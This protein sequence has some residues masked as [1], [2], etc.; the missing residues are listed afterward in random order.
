MI[1]ISTLD[2][3]E[4]ILSIEKTFGAE[5]FSK[6]SLRHHIK[7]RMLLVIDEGDIR[8][9]SIIMTRKGSTLARLYSIAIAEQ[10]RGNGYGLALLR[11]SENLA[12]KLGSDRISLEVAESNMVARA[13]YAREGYHSPKRLIAYYESG[14]AALRLW[15]PL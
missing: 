13:L 9:Y 14:E 12:I 10:Y 2:D 5:A 15:K 8:G 4:S 6:R 1:R 3:L 11:A 7:K